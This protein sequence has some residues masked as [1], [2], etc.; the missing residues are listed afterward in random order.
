MQKIFEL[1]LV[2]HVAG[3]LELSMFANASLPNVY[4]LIKLA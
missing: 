3:F 1:C 2:D 4:Y